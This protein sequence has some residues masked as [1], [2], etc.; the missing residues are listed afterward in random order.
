MLDLTYGFDFPHPKP[1][2]PQFVKKHLIP[3]MFRIQMKIDGHCRA[4]YKDEDGEI[5]AVGRRV[6]DVTYCRENTIEK[7][8]SYVRNVAAKLPNGTLIFGEIWLPGCT[9]REV[10]T[11]LANDSGDLRFSAFAVGAVNNELALMYVEQELKMF[12]ELSIPAVPLLYDYEKNSREDEVRLLQLLRDDYDRGMQVLMNEAESTGTEGFVIKPGGM[13][14]LQAKVVVTE[15]YDCVVTG[16]TLGKGKYSGYIGALTVSMVNPDTGELI[17]VAN[18]SGMTD[19]D[20]K[21]FSTNIPVGQVVEIA[22][23]GWAGR[24]RMRQPRFKRLRPDKSADM[25]LLPQ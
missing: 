11:A 5:Y 21:K 8:G 16:S 7:V 18:V 3:S 4:L 20:R 10:A 25:C 14:L 1:I 12:R 23:K 9:S 24:G 19:E 15:T 22:C 17:E 13:D 6:S 2:S